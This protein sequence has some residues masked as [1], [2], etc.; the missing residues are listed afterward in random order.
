MFLLLL[1]FGLAA[2]GADFNLT[3]G[4]YLQMGTRDSIIIR[5]RT[6]VPTDS[7]VLY[8]TNVTYPSEAV[9][10]PAFTT[11]HEVRLTGLLPDTRYYYYVGNLLRVTGGGP[12]HSFVTA[13]VA[14]KPTRIW[15]LGDSGTGD[16]FAKA[17]RDG[18]DTFNHNQPA[19]LWLMLGDNAYYS[20]TDEEYQAGVFE[21]YPQ[22]LR[23]MVLWPTIGNHEVWEAIGIGT[24]TFPYLEIFS[25]PRNGE[26]GGV[27]SGTEK[28]YSFDYGNIHFVCL[29]SQS[30][31]RTPGGPMLTWLEEDLAA[32][33]ADWII[34]FWHH[35]PYTRGTYNSDLYLE[36]TEMR[37]FALPILENHGVD[38]VLSGH[39]HVYERSFLL[40]GHY[41]YSTNLAPQM[42]LNAGMGR[43][44]DGGAY[45]KPAGGIGAHQ[46]TI[47]T[48]CGC[49]GDGGYFPFPRH[50]VMATN[51]SGY[52]S[53]VL[54][55]D[56][57]QL[58]G[59]FIRPNGE[60]EDYFTL[61]KGAPGTNVHPSLT[62]SRSGWENLQ[63]TWP[64]ARPDYHL[65]GADNLAGPP[66]WHS[67][68]NPPANLGRRN[69]IT[70]PLSDAQ[71]VFR[72][73]NGP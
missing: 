30:S 27:P 32:T 16:D 38:L 46:G 54:D 33:A 37:Q 10:S 12:G 4:P 19:D 44:N 68:T 28:Y 51:M 5:W 25:L 53:L 70:L 66:E 60:V 29:D 64:T 11:N 23:R 71:K 7:R 22:H 42:I 58:E 57:D 31:W 1:G 59:K 47:Y 45:C 14:A 21:T 65:E 49:S 62:V 52:G 69:V 17:V 24:N 20:G 56:G 43:T 73:R 67:I 35:P 63:L 34:A 36:L 39:S 55:I 3:R 13:P 15:V 18:F 50:P 61:V 72:L 9:F 41:S 26:A 48:V 40:N 6:D 2:W 8:G